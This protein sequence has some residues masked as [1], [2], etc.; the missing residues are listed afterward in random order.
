MT[1]QNIYGNPAAG[2]TFKD[3]DATYT[4]T[5]NGLDHTVGRIS[6]QWDRGANAQPIRYRVRVKCTT[7]GDHATVVGSTYDV[8]MAT[9][10]GTAQ[11]GNNGTTDAALTAA[12]ASNLT[13]IGSVVADIAATA[14]DNVFINTFTVNIYDRYVSFGLINNTAD[15]LKASNDASYITVYPVSDAIQAAA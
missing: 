1:Q 2:V 5:L 9:S 7:K 4:I 8:Y 14:A 3:S 13:F 11:D 12:K 10:D 15:A 6:D